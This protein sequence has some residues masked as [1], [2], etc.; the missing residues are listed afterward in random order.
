VEHALAEFLSKFTYLAIVA[1]LAAAGLGV[2]ISE[3]LT[4]LLAGGLAARGV[5]AYW[6][7]LATGYC[8]VVLGD[9]LIHHWGWRLGPAAYDHPRIQKHLSPA[10]QERLSRHFARHGF[11]TIVVAR[12]TP[13]LRAPIFFL[14]GASRL[15]RWKFFLADAISSAVTVPI[16]V[17]L[18][19]YFGEHLDEIR[20]RINHVQWFLVGGLAAG[21]LI[22]W[23]LRQRRRS[24]H[25]GKAEDCAEAR[26][27]P[28]RPE[29]RR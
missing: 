10:R 14:A 6:P 20:A 22:W 11:L 21:A 27:S 12:H 26:R 13:M 8:G 2:P 17:T 9:M 5:T 7:T 19:F 28:D 16:A 4:L 1:V 24:A 25:A 3:D 18:G 23:L 29:D 15:P